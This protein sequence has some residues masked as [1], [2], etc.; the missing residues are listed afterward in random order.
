MHDIR[1]V[2]E[3]QTNL[4]CFNSYQYCADEELKIPTLSYEEQTNFTI[5]KNKYGETNTSLQNTIDLTKTIKK[6]S[7]TEPLFQYFLDGSRKTYKVDDIEV[8][9]KI[10]PIMAGQIGVACCQRINPMKFS[11]AQL[12]LNN[13]IVLPTEAN[14]DLRNPGLFL[15]RLREEINKTL[16]N[17]GKRFNISKILTYPTKK[18]RDDEDL[19]YEQAGII[20]IQNEMIES[21]K[22]IVGNLTAK[23]LL[24]QNSYLIKDGSLQ[25][26]P[27]KSSDYREITKIKNN[28]RWVVGVSKLF[29]PELCKD[30]FGKS[31]A[32][33]LANL[34]LF[35]RT[36][37]F[38]L[39]YERDKN[40]FL[41]DYKYSVWYIRIRDKCFTDS[42]F[43]GIVKVEKILITDEEN[44]YGLDSELINLISANI[45]NERN[46]VCYGNDQRWA[47]HLYPI[48]LTELMINSRYLSN[49]HFLNIF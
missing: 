26:K 4:K 23:N 36:P 27:L 42:A 28:Y 44:I 11:L 7:N 5:Y 6:L 12:E 25:Y 30:K 47:N 18:D 39:Q 19:K 13:V 17:K 10:F 40:D 29:N 14:N 31:N 24:N 43:S 2:I 21:E 35:H 9:K 16:N 8:N 41:G 20:K 1:N 49:I 33:H 48:Y 38:M 3:A 37:A 15:N 32:S 22:I 46:P 45:I 34:S